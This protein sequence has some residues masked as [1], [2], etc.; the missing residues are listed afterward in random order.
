MDSEQKTWTILETAR[1]LR[2]GRNQ[3]YEG[4]KTGKIPTIRIGK[5]LLVPKAALDRLL[6]GQQ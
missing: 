5:R 2:I 6:D 3:A 1:I 4:A